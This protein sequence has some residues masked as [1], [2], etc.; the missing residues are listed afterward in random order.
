MYLELDVVFQRVLFENEWDEVEDQEYEP[1]LE[2]EEEESRK[3]VVRQ[4]KAEKRKTSVKARNDKKKVKSE[5]ISAAC[6]IFKKEWEVNQIKEEEAKNSMLLVCNGNSYGKDHPKDCRRCGYECE[7]QAYILQHCTYNFSTGITQRHDRVLN[8]ILHEVI[9]GRKNNDYYD[10]MVDT[11]PGPTRERPDIIMIQKDGPEVLLADVT[12]PYE[13]GVVAIEAA[14]EWKIEKYSHFIE[15]FARQGKRAVILPL[16]VGSLGTYWPDT[17]NSLKMLGLS[18]GQIRNLIP[19][20]SMIALESSKQIYWRHIFG[21][22]YRIV[23]EL[24]CTK[25]KQEARFGDEPMENVQVSD[26]FQ[27]FKTRERE[28]KS[29]EEK[30]RRSKS[31]RGKTWRG[32]KKH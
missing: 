17:S 32:S 20:I 19:D 29:E 8:R 28:K 24:Y 4:R 2:E 21:D 10:I 1:G 7:S 16:V 31:K 13:N 22:S 15:Y 9:K 5:D 27:P 23:T 18:D 26:R 25:N 3:V 30:K 11:E 12:V 6:A 14:W